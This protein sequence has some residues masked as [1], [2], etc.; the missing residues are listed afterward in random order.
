MLSHKTKFLISVFDCVFPFIQ[1]SICNGS[2]IFQIYMKFPFFI[3]WF[4]ISVTITYYFLFL[5]GLLNCTID[6]RLCSLDDITFLVT[7]SNL[8]IQFFR[9]LLSSFR[10]F[11]NKFN[12]MGFCS[13]CVCW[14]WGTVASSTT[15]NCSWNF[16]LFQPLPFSLGHK[17]FM[18][19]SIFL[20]FS[21]AFSRAW[22][23]PHFQNCFWES[24]IR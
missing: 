20:I 17:L 7:F 6:G 3:E 14:L 2:I 4:L 13:T 16:G 15:C 18:S 1:N 8:F 12:M 5:K 10:K 21:L 19:L 9:A 23:S 22:V 11:L 24:H